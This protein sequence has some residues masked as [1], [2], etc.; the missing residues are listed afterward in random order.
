MRLYVVT[1]EL[2]PLCCEFFIW[3]CT[4]I[5][6]G[7]KITV[8]KHIRYLLFH[9]V[10]A[11]GRITTCLTV[12]KRKLNNYFGKIMVVLSGQ[13][14]QKTVWRSAF[15][16]IR[17]NTLLQTAFSA[18]LPTGSGIIRKGYSIPVFLSFWE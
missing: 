15:L 5:I 10:S 18:M 2:V 16:I 8:L 7:E 1:G 14:R 13:N 17:Q 3:D 9:F 4:G 12:K 6:S 11:D